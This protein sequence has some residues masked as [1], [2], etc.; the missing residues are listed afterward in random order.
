VALPLLAG[1]WILPGPA[2]GEPVRV[3]IRRSEAGFELLR[4]GKPYYVQGAVYWARPDG[5]VPLEGLAACGANSVRCGGSLVAAILDAAAGLGMTATVG[6][7]LKMESV[8]G[9]DYG[10]PK[11]VREQLDQ[12]R[13]MVEK[14]KDHPALLFWGVGNELT[15]GY[16]NKKMWDALNDAAAMVHRLDPNHPTLTT[17]GDGSIRRGDVEELRTR[18][19][20]IDVLGI[21]WYKEIETVPQRVREAG[22]EKPYL[23]TEWGPSG[24]WQVPRTKWRVPIEET[25]TEKATRYLQRYQDTMLKD[26]ARCLGSYVF[27]WG[28]KQERTHTWYG[29]FLAS[30]ERTEAVNV[31]QYLW[32]GRPPANRAPAIAKLSIDDKQARDNVLVPPATPH[33]VEVAIHDPEGD[34]LTFLWEILP[35]PTQFGY[36]GRGERK[37]RPLAELVQETS[38]ATLRFLA[39]EESGNYR[40]FVIAKDGQGNAATA[41]VPFRVEP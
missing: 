31:M 12:M 2:Q 4:G 18:C 27:M 38:G 5:A 1:A 40:V 26:K 17:L 15:V 34:P 8:H 14:Y 25:S 30:G 20:E 10:D 9:F 7:P 13:A 41:N 19:P 6:L 11:A 28:Q 16:K 23:I 24:H 36:G 37:P 21:N 29:M 3:E 22:W 32:T 33:T 35:E 39:P